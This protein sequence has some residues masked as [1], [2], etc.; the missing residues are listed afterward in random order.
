MYRYLPHM[1][2][3]WKRNSWNDVSMDQVST[4][5]CVDLYSYVY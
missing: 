1:A 2:E 3:Y 4:S 5:F